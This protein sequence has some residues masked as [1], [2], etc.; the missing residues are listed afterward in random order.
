MIHKKHA[1]ADKKKKF[2][3]FDV[4]NNDLTY[5]NTLNRHHSDV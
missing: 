3:T 5:A 4:E 2:R 1:H